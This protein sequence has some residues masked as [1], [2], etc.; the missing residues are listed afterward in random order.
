MESLYYAVEILILLIG[1][2]A[3]CLIFSNA[4]E[5]LGDKLNLS[6]Q[7]TGSVLAA[8]G[9]ALPETIVPI[10]AIYLAS[11]GHTAAA[12]HDIAIGSIIGAPFL[13]GTL[14]FFLVGVTV[15]IFAKKRGSTNL[16]INPQHVRRDL[17]YFL[18]VFILA[19]LATFCNHQVKL[20]IA[21]MIGLSYAFYI[22]K[23]LQANDLEAEHKVTCID[24]GVEEAEHVPDLYLS[25]LKFPTSIPV[26]YFQIILGLLGIIFLAERFVHELEYAAGLWNISPL[27]LS[28]IITPIATELPEKVNSC[29]WSSQS[30]DSLA[31]G[32]LTGAMVFQASIPCS[33]GIL[34]TPWVLD[35]NAGLSAIFA[36]LGASIIYVSLLVHKKLSASTLVLTGSL[37]LL[38]LFILFNH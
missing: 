35:F 3:A 22:F 36:I 18:I 2:L 37:Y 14:A 31:I 27:I 33:I 29:I 6:N 20:A 38:Y 32:N 5:N 7:V 16:I 1:I 12:K 24:T 4:V 9:T 28:L 13:L 34:F 26:I 25:K 19:L 15:L 17:F 8:V 10:I 30:K 21:I 23:T 11:Q